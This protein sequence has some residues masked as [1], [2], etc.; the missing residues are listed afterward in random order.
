MSRSLLSN[1]IEQYVNGP[2]A[3][4][5]AVVQ[6]LREETAKLPMGRMQILPDQGALLALLARVLGARRALEVGTFTG[7]SALAVAEALP[8]DGQLITC[9]VSAEWTDMARRF[10]KQARVDS[11]IDLRLG[12]AAET[13]G[14]LLKEGGAG[15]F[16]LAFIDA[17]KLGYDT[18][19]EQALKLVRPGGVIALDNM[20]WGGAVA[21]AGPMD[22]DTRALHNLNL[23]V[24]KDERVDCVLLTVG[25]GLLLAR[26]R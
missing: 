10:W 24:A 2:P 7:Y 19:Y 16:D 22:D 8:P 3:R 26:R 1:E 4:V 12:P 5:S 14:R 18:Y 23:K 15:T 25:D 13:L 20:L 21:T 9:D 6:A 17:D 11:R